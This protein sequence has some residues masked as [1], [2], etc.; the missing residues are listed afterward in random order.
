MDRSGTTPTTP[1]SVR[2]VKAMLPD[3]Y[4]ETMHVFAGAMSC[5]QLFNEFL[6]EAALHLHMDCHLA[7]NKKED[8]CPVP[9][10]YYDG[11]CFKVWLV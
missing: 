6:H 5:V 10:V 11:Y 4:R 7:D 3:R 2:K 1:L 9:Y 8:L